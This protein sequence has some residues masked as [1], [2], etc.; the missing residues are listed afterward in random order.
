MNNKNYK[1]TEKKQL[2]MKNIIQMVPSN[3]LCDLTEETKFSVLAKK[4]IWTMF[5][6]N[7][8][9]FQA[10]KEKNDRRNIFLKS[11]SFIP[12]GVLMFFLTPDSVFLSIITSEIPCRICVGAMLGGILSTSLYIGGTGMTASWTIPLGIYAGLLLL[13]EDFFVFLVGHPVRGRLF[14]CV[15]VSFLLS[16]AAYIIFM[17]KHKMSK[18]LEKIPYADRFFGDAD[19]TKELRDVQVVLDKAGDATERDV[20]NVFGDKEPHIS[21]M[22]LALKAPK[23]AQI[24]DIPSIPA[25]SKE[26]SPA[27]KNMIIPI[28]FGVTEDGRHHYEDF[29][30]LIH[31]GIGGAT[32]MGK[33]NLLRH[34][35]ISIQKLGNADLVLIDPERIDL[36]PF[37]GEENVRFTHD[38]EVAKQLLLDVREEMD[39]RQTIFSQAEIMSISE[40]SGVMKRI[41]IVIDEYASFYT[42]KAFTKLLVNIARIGR[43]YGVHLVVATQRPD[44][45][46]L[47]EQIRCNLRT[48]LAFGVRDKGNAEVLSAKGAENIDKVGQAYLVRGKKKI[49]LQTP[50]AE[51]WKRKWPNVAEC[52]RKR[53]EDRQNNQNS[54][55]NSEGSGRKR[56][57][58]A[59][60]GRKMIK[61]WSKVA[62]NGRMWPKVA[63]K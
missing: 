57:K 2:K 61:R 18:V 5:F 21:D 25:I 7:K 3:Y 59:E 23:E 51:P 34:L 56:P 39:R 22:L 47:H 45:K 44:A 28:Y 31:L 12:I 41:V 36:E 62:E 50:L 11:M 53:K 29:V 54:P 16:S 13:E 14:M 42:D 37:A 63:E 4:L 32:E 9:I 1:K 33:S 10:L 35:V 24:P 40:Y 49:L 15:G 17:C 8:I 27:P 6:K 46:V 20:Q 30:K 55:K 58:M 38:L 19:E 52:G 48:T 60:S 26:K 43:K